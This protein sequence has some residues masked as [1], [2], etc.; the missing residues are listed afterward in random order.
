MSYNNIKV[1]SRELSNYIFIQKTV[2][3]SFYVVK[4]EYTLFYVVTR[5]VLK[6]PD[7]GVDFSVVVLVSLEIICER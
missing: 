1:G 2:M 5:L 4:S 6:A 3:Y 7:A